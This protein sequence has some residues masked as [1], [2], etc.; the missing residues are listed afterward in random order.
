MAGVTTSG[1]NVSAL[2]V[3]VEVANLDGNDQSTVYLDVY[4][5]IN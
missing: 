5:D 4:T 1:S 2:T 3:V